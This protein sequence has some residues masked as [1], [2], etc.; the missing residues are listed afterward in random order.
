MKLSLIQS[1]TTILLVSPLCGVGAEGTDLGGG[2]ITRT[3][4][5]YCADLTLD[6]RD[7]QQAVG[8]GSSKDALGIYLN[9][10]NSGAPDGSLFKLAQLSTDLSSESIDKVTPVFMFQL[11][12]LAGRS[13]DKNAL[14]GK[15]SYADSYVRSA[16]QNGKSMASTAVLVLNVWMYAADILYKGA[17]TCQKKV[18]ADNPGQFDIGGGG[19]DEFIALWIGSGQTHGSGQGFGLYALAE[20]A[21]DLF[22]TGSNGGSLTE[23][24][25]NQQ[26]KLLYQEGA[27]LFSMPDVCTKENPKSPK[28]LWSV[29]NRINSQMYIPLVQMLII[30]ILEQN[31]EGTQVYATAVIPQA[32]Q[33]RPSTFD[34]LKEEL[35]DG[36]PNF[37]RTETILGDLQEIYACFGISCDDIGTP[38]NDYK[39]DMPDCSAAVDDAPMALYKPS[40]DVHPVRDLILLLLV[41]S[42]GY[43]IFKFEPHHHLRVLS[44]YLL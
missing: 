14:L 24:R 20:N 5:E 41:F 26:L 12:G 43:L 19:L 16:I 38:V 4:V 30:S 6:V 15:G 8:G 7:I 27:S 1:L 37:R 2:V 25:A 36:D 3:D 17:N 40:T 18:E 39:Y 29:I 35:L 28:K 21:N 44:C 31:P 11:Y 22:S 42:H 13:M 23:G 10:R 9:G 32:A 34:R 33:C